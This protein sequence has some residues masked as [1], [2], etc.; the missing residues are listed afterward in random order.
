MYHLVIPSAAGIKESILEA[1]LG[2][3]IR[4]S[5]A[6]KPKESPILKRSDSIEVPSVGRNYPL[7]QRGDRDMENHV[8]FK[9]WRQADFSARTEY[10]RCG[11]NATLSAKLATIG[12]SRNF[13][14]FRPLPTRYTP[15]SARFL[16][17]ISVNPERCAPPPKTA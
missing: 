8:Y 5:P 12:G 15:S 11:C 14:E 10:T 1:S 4:G 17:R 3:S 13:L 9:G 7:T 16:G 6:S 2:P